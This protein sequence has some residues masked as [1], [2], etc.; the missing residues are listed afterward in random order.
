M[1]AV[2]AGHICLDLT[3]GFGETAGKHLGD[4]LL[5]GKLTN[6]SGITLSTGGTVS[7]TGIALS[8]L[9][10]STQLM[11][12]IGDDFFGDIVLKILQQYDL[13]S[14][15]AVAKGAKTSYTVIVAP[16]GTDRIFLHDPG[17]NDT[18]CAD[19]IA[20]D[21]VGKARLFHFGYPPVMRRMYQNG[22]AELL[23]IFK[24]AQAVGVTTS[25][26]M[27]VPDSRSEAGQVDWEGLLTRVLPH[28]DIFAPSIEEILYMLHREEFTRLARMSAGRDFV[29]AL[30]INILQG[31]GDRILA[32]GAKIALIKCGK[33]GC[34]IRTADAAT[35]SSM[36]RGQPAD[37][38]NWGGRELF[39]ETFKAPNVV[40]TTGA[41][42]A[43]IAGFLAALLKGEGVEEALKIACATGAECVQTYDALSG[44]KTLDET[45]ALIAK[46]WAKEPITVNGA[47]WQY[48]KQG[49]VWFGKQDIQYPT[50]V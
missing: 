5:P 7:N 42:D 38:S 24:K 33:R 31:L 6:V 3:P 17:A 15:M 19:D 26:D 1:E 43:C 28:V 35:L 32:L 14:A 47:Y 2:V 34:Y 46:G 27:T 23:D 48:D 45:R 18:F 10:V 13:G 20:F 50:S 40:S 49:T 36:G 8:I 25:M 41:G 39:E 9:G 29:E 44:I 22:G 4:I 37:K 16:P 21:L 12:K 11:G 30:D